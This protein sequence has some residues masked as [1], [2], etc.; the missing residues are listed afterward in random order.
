MKGEIT[1]ILYKEQIKYLRAQGVWPAQFDAAPPTEELKGLTVKAG[2][3][4]EGEE[5]SDNDL[6]QNT[7]RWDVH[8][9]KKN[10]FCGYYKLNLEW[11]K[12]VPGLS[13][14]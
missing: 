8:L 9:S 5:E 13:C 1:T 4:S 3:D 2:T 10:L 6:F 12:C 11:T 7:N 14:H